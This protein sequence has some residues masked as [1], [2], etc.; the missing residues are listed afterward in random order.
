ML[1]STVCIAAAAVMFLFG[2]FILF[3]DSGSKKKKESANDGSQFPEDYATNFHSTYL[4][5][6]NIE[7]TIQTLA[8]IY[9]DNPYMIQL[10]ERSLEYINGEYG[11]FQTALRILNPNKDDVVEKMHA[12]IISVE[13]A[14]KLGLPVAKTE[15]L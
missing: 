2:I 12:E 6:G 8:D 13:I 1:N 11:D 10:L 14:K 4:E 15:Q 5:I 3:E 9:S 7:T